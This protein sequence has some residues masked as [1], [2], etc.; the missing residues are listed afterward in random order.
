MTDFVRLSGGEFLMG[1]DTFFPEEGPVHSASVEGFEIARHAVTNAEFAEFVE[2]TGYITVAER[3]LEPRKLGANQ[4]LPTDPGSLVFIPT[5]GPVDLSNWRLWWQWTPGASWRNPRGPQSNIEE[6]SD[7]PV[8]QVSYEDANA[9]AAWAGA[10]LPTEK[11]WEFAARG[12]LEAATFAWGGEPNDGLMANTWQGS[13][14][15]DNNGARGWV[16]TAPVGSFPANGFGLYEMTG[17]TWEWT[18]SLW[19][20]RHNPSKSCCPDPSEL[21]L[22]T[23]SPSR[24]LKGGSHLCSPSYCLRYRPA[25]RSQQTEDSATT[26]IGLR[27]ARSVVSDK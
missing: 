19:N 18:S 5:N 6:L 1:S 26:H 13:F 2:Q 22:R 14:P 3:A 21:Q 9:Y 4:S 15:Y 23:N 12:G 10:R 11:E 8:V 25:A 16:Y 24:V 17:N 20:S 27:L 7:H